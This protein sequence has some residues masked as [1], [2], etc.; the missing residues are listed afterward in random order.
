MRR[1]DWWWLLFWVALIL[2]A[3]FLLTG[4]PPWP[5]EFRWET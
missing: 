1:R 2:A 5:D 3:R 4:E